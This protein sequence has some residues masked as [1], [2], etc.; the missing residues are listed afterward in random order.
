MHRGVF[1]RATGA[2]A[3][4]LAVDAAAAERRGRGQAGVHV[5][6]A[7]HERDVHPGAN[8]VRHAEGHVVLL[9]G[10]VGLL[11]ELGLRLH[12]PGRKP[13]FLAVKRPARPYKSAI[14][15]R[16]TVENAKGA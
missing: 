16:F 8:D 13:P 5:R 12:C 15:N 1:V 9:H 2:K 14:Q 6:A 11:R 10:D 3:G 7:R 4:D